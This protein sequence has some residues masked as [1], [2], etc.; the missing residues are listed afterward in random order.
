MTWLQEKSTA[1]HQAA[2]LA[3]LVIRH[4]FENLTEFSEL[5]QH[6][7]KLFTATQLR[8]LPNGYMEDGI[9]AETAKIP[10]YLDFTKP[11]RCIKE[12][13]LH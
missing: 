2:P 7:S 10:D 12:K 5:L 6:L 11:Y 8:S 1:R 4:E 3:L 13:T 9:D